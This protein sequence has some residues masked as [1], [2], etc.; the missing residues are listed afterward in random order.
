MIMDYAEC[1]SLRCPGWITV[2]TAEKTI[3]VDGKR[4]RNK[5]SNGMYMLRVE[6]FDK[7]GVETFQNAI[8]IFSVKFQNSTPA[9]DKRININ[10]PWDLWL[11]QNRDKLPWPVQDIEK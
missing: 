8:V 4:T 1:M 6:Y 3:R 11:K 9:K 2:N 7:T 10:L 5:L